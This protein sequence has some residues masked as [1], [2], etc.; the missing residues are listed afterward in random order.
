MNSAGLFNCMN[1]SYW[2]SNCCGTEK[3]IHLCRI[4]AHKS[5]QSVQDTMT[6]LQ[7]YPASDRIVDSVGVRSV[8]SVRSVNADDRNQYTTVTALMYLKVNVSGYARSW[9]AAALMLIIAPMGNE[10]PIYRQMWSAT[11]MKRERGCWQVNQEPEP[12]P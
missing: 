6:A 9:I 8:I 4:T 1:D 11:P 12:E 7:Q 5:K 2:F 3:V 10:S